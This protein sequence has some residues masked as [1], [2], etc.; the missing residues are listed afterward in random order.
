MNFMSVFSFKFHNSNTMKLKLLLIVC[1][2]MHSVIGWGQHGHREVARFAYRRTTNKGRKFL[3]ANGIE[4]AE[5]FAEASLWADTEEA[6]VAYPG[7]DELHFSN[8]PW[9]NCQP[10]VFDRDCGYDGSGACIVSG[11]AS[12][13]SRA[14]DASLN[15]TIRTD[16][17]KFLSHLIADIHQPLHTGFAEDRGGVQI[18]ITM[19]DDSTMS[20]H[21]LWDYGLLDRLRGEG[22]ESVVPSDP[23]I[24]VKLTSENLET[25]ILDYASALA[26]ESSTMFTCRSA[27]QLDDGQYITDRSS[28][29][30]E[31]LTSRSRIASM[32]L[33]TAAR[34]LAELLD[35]IA[36][37]QQISKP[38]AG[39]AGAAGHVAAASPARHIA[40]EN[41][42]AVLNMDLDLDEIVS[43]QTRIAPDRTGRSFV[44]PG[45]T[46]Q[47]CG[48]N[49]TDIT[50]VKTVGRYVITCYELL[51]VSPYYEPVMTTPFKVKF[52]N[53]RSEPIVI[54][55]DSYCFPT[56]RK[57]F[58]VNDLIRI[59]LHLK[60]L[61]ID[62][63]L[64]EYIDDHYR[65]ERIASGGGSSFLQKIPDRAHPISPGGAGA[66][67]EHLRAVR[68]RHA[69]KY[70]A[71]IAEVQAGRYPSLQEKWYTDC[72]HAVNDI[73]VVLVGRMQV[74]LHK[75]TILEKTN[76]S[77]KFSVLRSTDQRDGK[78]LIILVDSNI[79]DGDIW[80]SIVQLLRHVVRTADAEAMMSF[81]EKRHT[82][83]QEITDL[84][85][86][87][88]NRG[89]K[90]S[91]SKCA[92]HIKVIENFC[93]YHGHPDL[94]GYLIIEYTVSRA[95]WDQRKI[96]PITRK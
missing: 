17:I 21:Q 8:T 37:A 92:S 28:P 1:N 50:M 45:A 9:R 53:S 14:I 94:P 12:A 43:N 5:S 31:Y 68:E 87:L 67:P 77:M 74:Y 95:F 76:P 63:D 15:L 70:N 24:P 80:L 44:T 25:K 49:L 39:G 81:A 60:G 55:L 32:R 41:Y 83:Y 64:S 82:L 36:N 79:F 4:S 58:T 29:T 93:L 10:F 26:T 75:R 91:P 54:P 47:V 7:S 61:N 96:V 22:A 52:S 23:E 84:G 69:R 42:F 20:L 16:A 88:E 51:R 65:G 11:I 46:Y 86:I 66:S 35:L 78:E 34:R 71:Q 89:A 13:V 3:K 33:R 18:D 19:N 73:V 6:R 56:A 2:I 30:V 85:Y 27:Y 59:L 90:L 72:L 62:A 48:R 57:D 38:L 40:R